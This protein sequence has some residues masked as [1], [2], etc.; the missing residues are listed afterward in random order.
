[1][2]KPNNK[3]RIE[4][5]S[6]LEDLEGWFAKDVSNFVKILIKL[7]FLNH[8]KINQSE[9]FPKKTRL[10]GLSNELRNLLDSSSN[11]KVIAY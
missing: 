10:P 6:K 4:N 5:G 3:N 11:K 2:D 8:D 1:M 7:E 9:T